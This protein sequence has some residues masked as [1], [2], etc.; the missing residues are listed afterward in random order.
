[1]ELLAIALAAP[2]ERDVVDGGVTAHVAVAEH[3][4]RVAAAEPEA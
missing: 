4:R 1:V 2:D 3:V